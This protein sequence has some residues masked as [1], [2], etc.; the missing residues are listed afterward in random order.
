MSNW[1]TLSRPPVGF[2]SVDLL[3]AQGLASHLLSLNAVL[4][5]A[6]LLRP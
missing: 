6:L 2:D 3:I 4:V 1:L 5:A